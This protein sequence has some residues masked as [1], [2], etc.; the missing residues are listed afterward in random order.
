[1]KKITKQG[2]I[3]LL[4][5]ALC[6]APIAGASAQASSIYDFTGHNYYTLNIDGRLSLI[7]GMVVMS[8]LISQSMEQNAPQEVQEFYSV[9]FNHYMSVGQVMAGID[10]FYKQRSLDV[11]L[12]HVYMQVTKD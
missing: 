7:F 8:A 10:A 5:F 2:V 1:M 3:L 11:P 4:A 6:M 9:H 12:V